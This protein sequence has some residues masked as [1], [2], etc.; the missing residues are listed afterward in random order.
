MTLFDYIAVAAKILFIVGL[1]FSTVPIMVWF[2]RRGAAWMQARVGPNRV[3]IFGLMQP[4]ADV[5]KL[6]SKEMFI[7]AAASKFYYNLAPAISAIAPVAAMA[8]IPFGSYLIIGD[9]KVNLQIASLDIG[10]LAVLAFAGLE[11][12]PIMLA[13]WASNNKYSMLGA[14]RG[15]SQMISYEIALGLALVSML[16]V[17]G[18][19]DL[20]AMV[21]Y[22]D[23]SLLGFIPR[24]G[25]FLNPL[26]AL[27]FM[28]SIFAETNRL[29]FDLPEGESELVA[30]YHLEYGASKFA[31]FF[32]AEYVA[33]LMASGLFITIFFGGYGLIPGMGWV[34]SFFQSSLSPD[35]FQNLTAIAQIAAFVFKVGCMMFFF[36][37][38]RWTMPRFRY[39]QLMHLGWKILFPIALVNLLAVALIIAWIGV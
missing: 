27:I 19:L 12:Y 4:V 24:W 29:P 15:S 35:M 11:V 8:A 28:I 7:P 22:Q 33:M 20:N 17:Y 38:V 13:G 5:L 9:H 18:T 14:L 16:L 31:L 21:V 10:I 30:G 37:W 39:D 23:Q 32:F 1:A 36:V 6:L 34:L 3:G 25:V 2:E 26:A